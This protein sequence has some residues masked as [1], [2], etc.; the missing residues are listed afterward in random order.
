MDESAFAR[1][2]SDLNEGILYHELIELHCLLSKTKDVKP[3]GLSDSENANNETVDYNLC[4]RQLN[5]IVEKC[6]SVSNAGGKKSKTPPPQQ[7]TTPGTP[8]PDL[9]STPK[10]LKSSNFFKLVSRNYVLVFAKL[11]TK[12][13]DVANNLLNYLN[14]NSLN[15]LSSIAQ[16]ATVVLID[17]F[18][19][20]PNSLGA[21]INFSVNQVYKILKKDPSA[22]GNLIYLL[23]SLTKYSTRADID[24]KLQ[25]KLLKIV[26]KALSSLPITFD[27]LDNSSTANDRNT[28]TISLKKNYILVLRNLS[29]LSV[30][31]NYEHLLAVSASSTSGGAKMKPDTIMAHQHQFQTGLLNS[32]EKQI[33]YGLSNFCKDI[34]IATVE[35]IAHLFINFIPTGKFNP[36]EYLVNLYRLP[37]GTEEWTEDLTGLKG[38]EGVVHPKSFYNYNDF[39]DMLESNV[40]QDLF[41]TGIVEAVVFFVQLE[42][43]QNSEYLSANLTSIIDHILMK[44]ANIS[45]TENNS[46]I[47]TSDW[48]KLLKHWTTVIE[49]LV[50]EGSTAC[51][52][53]LIHYALTQFDSDTENS[54]SSHES[55]ASGK[56]SSKKP[57]KA[58][59]A[60][61]KRID[62]YHNPYQCSLIL[63][64]VELLLPF[65]IDFNSFASKDLQT[66]PKKDTK[67]EEETEETDEEKRLE[68]PQQSILVQILL[69]LLVNKDDYIRNYSLSTLLMY[70]KINEVEVNQLV[71]L[72]FHLFNG[73]LS[74][75]TEGK[76][77]EVSANLNTNTSSMISVRLLSYALALLALI[78]QTESINL[79]NS[80]I[81]RI[82]SYCT[83]GLKHNTSYSKTNNLKNLTC[84]IILSSLVTLHNDS[85]FVK[86]NSSQFLVFW[87][88][89]LTS[90]YVASNLSGASEQG[91]EKEILDNLK[92]RNTS[93]IC[94]LNYINTVDLTP[95]SLKQLQFLLTKAYNYL[96]YL[97]TNVES[98]SSV[99]NFNA[100]DFNKDNFYLNAVNNLIFSNYSY[101]DKLLIRNGIVSSIL[102]GK[103]IILKNFS[104]LATY[105]K[106]DINSSMIVFVTKLITDS[107]IFSVEI[108]T[109]KEKDRSKS[110]SSS[111]SKKNAIN[112]VSD[113][114]PSV[115]LLNELFNYNFGV[116]SKFN[117]FSANINELHH[118]DMEDEKSSGL[119]YKD[120]FYKD[121]SFKGAIESSSNHNANPWFDHLEEMIFQG[122]VHSVTYD[123]TVFINDYYS[124]LEKYAPNLTT[125]L[126]DLSIELFQLIFPYLTIKVQS[127]LLEQMRSSLTSK[128]ITPLRY[129]AV[130]VNAS[131]TLHGVLKS[132]H[133]KRLSLDRSIISTCIDILK[134]IDVPSQNL[135][136]INSDSIGLAA[137][138]V[139]V[140]NRRL[141]TEYMDAHVSSIIND[142]NPLARGKALLSMGKIYS[143]TGVG[144][145]DVYNAAYQ[146]LIDPN[147]IVYFYS[148]RAIDL[149]FASK[150][151][152]NNGLLPPVLARIFD[153]YLNNLYGYQLQNHAFVN[154]KYKF[155][156]IGLVAGILKTFVTSLGPNLRSLSPENRKQLKSLIISLRYTIGSLS[157][158]DNMDIFKN[159]LRLLQELVIFDP[160]LLD[161]E[162]DFYSST[163]ISIISK[164]L[165]LGLSS[166][167]ATSLN[168]DGIFP[169]NSSFGLYKLGYSCLTELIKVYGNDDI[170][171]KDVVQLIWVSFNIKPCEEL[172]TLIL[173]WMESSLELN[174]FATLN[175]LFKI[176]SKKLVQPYIEVNYQQKLLPLLQRQK[177]KRNDTIDFKDEEIENI[178]DG[179]G[180]GGDIDDK[181]EPISWEFKL[182]IYDLLNNLLALAT[183]NSALFERLKLRIS[184]LV[185]I[186]FLG[187][188]SPINII[189]LRGISLLDKVLGL[190]G[191]LEDPMYAGVS[192]LEQQ[193]AQ[194][195][196]AIVPCFNSGSSAEVIVNAVNVS[197]KFINLPRIKF[198]S[199]QR[200]L[201]TLIYFLEELSSNKFIRFGFLEN[202]SEFGRKSIQVSI[203]NCWALVRLNSHEDMK[204]SRRQRNRISTSGS[205]T[206]APHGDKNGDVDGDGNEDIEGL[207]GDV[208]DIDEEEFDLEPENEL[209]ETLQNYS[210][211]LISLW[212]VSLKEFSTLKY[213]DNNSKELQMYSNYWI[214]FISVLSLELEENT[215]FVEDHLGGDASAFFFI[216]FSQ[217]V[218]SLI[219]NNKNIIEVL[220]SLDSLVKNAELVGILFHDELFGEIVDL[221]DRLLLIEDDTE[222]QV[223][224]IEIVH[225]MFQTYFNSHKGLLEGF[226]KLFELIRLVMLPLF[227]YLPF[228]RTDYDANDNQTQLV[229]RKIDSAPT[230]VIIK[231]VFQTLVTMLPRFPDV[232]RV[233]LYSCLLFIIAKIYEFKNELLISTVLPYL[234]QIIKELKQ[235]N[236][237][238]IST[239]TSIIKNYYSISALSTSSILT[240]M[241]LI[242]IGDESLNETESDI[243]VSTLMEMIAQPE[244]RPMGVQCIRSLIQQSSLKNNF[245]V[246]KM[247]IKTIITRLV[248][249]SKSQV[250]SDKDISS[251]DTKLGLGILILFVK[252]QTDPQTLTSLYSLIIPLV[253]RMK[254]SVNQLFLHDKLILLINHNPAS[255]KQV[256]NQGLS[257][258]QRQE[259]ELL[260]KLDTQ[261]YQPEDND[262]SQIQLKTFG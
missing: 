184:D 181:N 232:V 124:Y 101:N 97:E 50:K 245:L 33:V 94:L 117:D 248:D 39:K 234:H 79:Q 16:L 95:E 225:S 172:K 122:P 37:A 53:I 258:S 226:D 147:P 200:I 253:V 42:H 207:G 168:L 247:L 8:A 255:F 219:K 57:I 66:S 222:I 250:V 43:Y 262:D 210:T 191:H 6:S 165:K 190:F 49:Y 127:S 199:K 110:K 237:L 45:L 233:D 151:V 20:Y 221:F 87:K 177:K 144:E 260:V 176:S 256:V 163:L 155:N 120:P 65:G 100:S 119:F 54:E 23:N 4:L 145:N 115:V 55:S 188:T 139:A 18:E 175:S 5:D 75:L 189:K 251:I 187:S 130:C 47:Q 106:N 46:H 203:L 134:R 240:Y 173:I 170:L 179:E 241:V 160:K 150:F 32:L 220:V 1:S 227:N 63:S 81:V 259:T 223:K 131:V 196:S 195:I 70:S 17:L 56:K 158:D 3:E 178:V 116:T 201:K 78:K 58:S 62:V 231:Q 83:Q 77:A 90:Q 204:Q 182:F 208:D 162:V 252:S 28:S 41:N 84:W 228:L 194:I 217:C 89:L 99:T 112:K 244:N 61:S 7:T 206:S 82:L 166:T 148:L 105:L 135:I 74:V 156:S 140:N 118:S 238:L 230:L 51:H 111:S 10:Q 236:S 216:L 25:S 235:L 26:H 48:I 38:F 197:S 27:S 103:K 91:P 73:E 246:T 257:A 213:N 136:D 198:Y 121:T 133:T 109:G 24:E 80:T 2:M 153:T 96:T 243:M 129:K 154:L 30:T 169:F 157:I 174:W 249:Q 205:S 85:E 13:Y 180:A 212:I 125:S 35:L 71:L 114:D 164:N 22:D 19:T 107:K 132:C 192:I 161:D 152:P 31:A 12:I 146:L 202:M 141:V 239:F 171:T 21:L 102:Y 9:E 261:T 60:S 126:V 209:I 72:C 137:S 92:L 214:N 149:L 11:P 142:T 138:F 36:I 128:A 186:A 159:I 185:K 218:E 68:S 59:R 29:A 52:D 215:K 167:S 104:K 67:D 98:V 183:K 123:P 44:F 211:L 76:A 15:Q 113:L 229:L 254:D 93:L 40:D 242:T 14:L 108:A 193:Q 64:I 143:Y 88:S 86:L 224:L 34:R 69:K